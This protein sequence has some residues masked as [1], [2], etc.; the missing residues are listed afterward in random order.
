MK[1]T[2]TEG[3]GLLVAAIVGMALT[4]ATTHAASPPPT[5]R[6]RQP[7]LEARPE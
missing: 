3:L 7:Q 6:R 4:L 1:L 2:L 5:R